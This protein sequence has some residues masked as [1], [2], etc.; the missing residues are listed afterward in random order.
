M[1]GCHDR[2]CT[3]TG[4]GSYIPCRRSSISAADH[5]SE[6]RTNKT[7][8]WGCAVYFDSKELSSL[9]TASH[10]HTHAH[11]HAHTLPASATKQKGCGVLR[12]E[13]GSKGQQPTPRLALLLLAFPSARTRVVHLSQTAS[14]TAHET[15][16]ERTLKYHTAHQ[17][18]PYTPSPAKC[19][20]LV[21]GRPRGVLACTP[22]HLL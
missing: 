9:H 8:S 20:I 13:Y 21:Q 17:Y 10:T 19:L 16:S 6:S 1:S 18:I 22:L 15:T 14:F 7:L 2:V 11:A 4:G 3:R 12:T 5:R